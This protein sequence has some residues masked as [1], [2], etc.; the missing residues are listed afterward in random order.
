VSL[1]LFFTALSEFGPLSL[2]FLLLFSEPPQPNIATASKM[3]VIQRDSAR[4]C[5]DKPSF[6]ITICLHVVIV[7]ARTLPRNRYMTLSAKKTYTEMVFFCKR[8][9]IYLLL[10]ISV[11]SKF[12][13]NIVAF[14]QYSKVINSKA[15]GNDCTAT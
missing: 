8:G 5:I 1:D 12:D 3:D 14:S 6:L 11:K 4:A 10:Y 13:Q 2:L 15:S 7:S 9:Q